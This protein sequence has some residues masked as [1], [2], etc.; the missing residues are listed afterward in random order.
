MTISLIPLLYLLF[1][2]WVADFLFQ[3]T[4][5]AT[6]KSKSNRVLLLHTGTYIVVMFFTL[7]LAG[8]VFNLEY[9]TYRFL[10]FFPITF[11]FHTVQDYATS[12]MTSEQFGK[13]NFNGLTG[14]FTIVGFDQFLHYSQ[15][16]LTYY[17][18]INS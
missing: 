18:L 11:A 12:R 2:H 6:M 5:M 3:T 14:G 15:M 10:W 13:S 8:H 4:Y 17:F 7:G 9:M 1:C 16:F